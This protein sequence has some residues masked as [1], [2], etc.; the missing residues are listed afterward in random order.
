MAEPEQELLHSSQLDER[1]RHADMEA[2]PKDRRNRVFVNLLATLAFILLLAVVLS[3][4]ALTGDPRAILSLQT[5][6]LALATWILMGAGLL[7]ATINWRS[8]RGPLGGRVLDRARSDFVLTSISIVALFTV[9]FMVVV[10]VLALVAFLDLFDF[11][12]AGDRFASSFA[13]FQTIMLLVYV[14]ALVARQQNPSTF[15]PKERALKVAK[16]LTPVAATIVFFGVLLALGLPQSIGLLSTLENHQAVYIVTLGVLLEFMAMRT[17]LRLPTLLSRFME[18]I[19]QARR[20]NEDMRQALRK[21][22]LRTY[23]ISFGFVAVSMAF[24]GAIASG[25]V[26]TGETRTT[27]ALTIFYTGAA[28][29]FLGLIAV[30][31]VQSRH[32]QDRETGADALEELLSRKRRGPEAI[33]RLSIYAVTGFLAAAFL[34]LAILIGLGQFSDKETKVIEVEGR[35]GTIV[36]EEKVVENG[37]HEKY[38][39]D[40]FLVAL[41][42]AAGPFGY[43]YNRELKRIEAMDEK[44]PD[45]LRDIAESA[46]AGMTLPR[47]LVSAA[48]G[49]YGALTP[50]IKQMAAQVEWGVDFGDALQRFAKRANTPLIDR[51]VSLV[52]EA[53]RAGGSVVDILTAASDD[54]REIKQIVSERNEQMKLYKVVVYIAFFVFISVVLILSA[55]FIPAFKDA[56]GAASGESVGGIQFKDFDP[57]DFNTLFFHAAIVQCIGGGLVGGVLTRGSPVAG[58]GSISVMV[59]V[60]WICFRLLIG[61]M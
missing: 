6:I 10:E 35:R 43:F 21:R 20:A 15:Q 25:A 55:Q 14:L 61:L 46:R 38:G 37:I 17:R 51:T 58:F 24:A 56:V 7:F 23:L 40:A 18:T 44:F 52:V 32:L 2:S 11:G 57:D 33:F 47:A 22:A 34:V 19:E 60:A 50:E 59:I 54:A 49:T 36:L 3:S 41:I 48:G 30:R 31:V 45:F 1:L 12:A 4:V 39:T 13:L 5:L 27:L 16:V 28:L 8:V 26:Q 29:I 53:Q 9:V 42:L